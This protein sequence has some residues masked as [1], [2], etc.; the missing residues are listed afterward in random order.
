LLHDVAEDTDITLDDLSREFPAEVMDILK[1]LTH[2]EGTDYFDYVRAIK[3]NPDAV[4]VKLA[5]LEHNSDQSRIADCGMDAETKAY[6][7]SKYAKA[8]AIL[9]ED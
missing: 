5:D 9:L 7:R 2:A 3:G 8:K 6:F 4:K 1:L